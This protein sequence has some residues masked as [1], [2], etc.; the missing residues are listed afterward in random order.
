MTYI[1]QTFTF[2]TIVT[3]NYFTDYFLFYLQLSKH[4]LPIIWHICTKK[5]LK[6]LDSKRF[7]FFCCC[8]NV[9]HCSDRNWIT[10]YVNIAVQ[11]VTCFLSDS[12][13]VMMFLF[14]KFNLVSLNGCNQRVDII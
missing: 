8:W 4:Y 14:S 2:M 5:L 7:F 9:Q 6:P 1:I 11:S 3:V 10:L 12:L 13:S